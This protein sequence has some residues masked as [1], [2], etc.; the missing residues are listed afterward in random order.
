MESKQL[1]FWVP[2]SNPIAPLATPDRCCSRQCLPA[3]WPGPV[4]Q[5]S[6]KPEELQCRSARKGLTEV[7]RGT[8]RL[9][10]MPSLWPWKILSLDGKKTIL[11]KDEHYCLLVLTMVCCSEAP[12][13]CFCLP[14]F[15]KPKETHLCGHKY[16]CH[17]VP[18]FSCRI[19]LFLCFCCR[20]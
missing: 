9:R 4:P 10:R 16:S 17:S 15:S 11:E 20:I 6:L 2:M 5:C 8:L 14:T 13:P 18:V 1:P 12:L 3:L 19:F 7:V